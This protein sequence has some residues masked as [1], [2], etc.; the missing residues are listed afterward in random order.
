METPPK[1]KK[2]NQPSAQYTLV[3]IYAHCLLLQT[4]S[5]ENAMQKSCWLKVLFERSTGLDISV[6]TQI[7]SRSFIQTRGEWKVMINVN[8][9]RNCEKSYFGQKKKMVGPFP[10]YIPEG[11]PVFHPTHAV[12]LLTRVGSVAISE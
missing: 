11:S 9:S 7:I 4:N 5:S 12:V 8:I 1:I 6:D 2:I 3:L 10:L